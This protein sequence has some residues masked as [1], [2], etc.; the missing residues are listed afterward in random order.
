VDTASGG[1]RQSDSESAAASAPDLGKQPCPKP[2]T[3]RAETAD[4]PKTRQK[5]KPHSALE[6]VIDLTFRLPK[7]FL[8][9]FAVII[10]GKEKER[11]KKE[12][13]YVGFQDN[14]DS[15]LPD[16]SALP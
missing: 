3:S 10:H 2:P 4:N 1:L 7:A 8:K 14:Q 12:D 16:R 5:L 9:Q 13:D 11:V 15:Q 6:C